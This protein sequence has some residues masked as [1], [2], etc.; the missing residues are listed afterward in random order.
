MK[1]NRIKIGIL[2]SILLLFTWSC[3]D[4]LD[5][6][7]MSRLSTEVEI[8]PSLAAPLAYGSFSIL[9]ILESLNDSSGLISLT[10]DSL[11]LVSFAD[12][13]YSVYAED[14][15]EIPEHISSET[16]IESDINVAGW[17]ALPVGSSYDF[18]KIEK[19]NFEIE[20]DDRIDSMLIKSGTLDLEAYSEFRHAGVLNITSHNIIDPAGDTLDISFTISNTDGTFANDSIFDL[21]GY[22]M[23]MDEIND[24]AVVKIY[25]NLTLIKSPADIGI[26]EEAGMIMTFS[27]IEYKSVF[28]FI[29]E[30]EVTDMNETLEIGFFDAI[31]EIPEIYFADPQFNIAVHNSFGVPLNLDITK[32]TARS[33]IDGSL[34]DLEF[35]ND[36]MNPFTVRAPRVDQL[37]QTITTE[38]YY[39]V[40]TTNIDDILSSIPD[41]IEL[42]FGA[43][44]GNPSG[45]TEQNF[46]LDTS[47]VVVEAEVLLPLWLS[48]SGYTLKDTLDTALD[49]LL[50]NLAFIEDATFRLTTTNEWP[51]EVAIQIYFM[52]DAFTKVDSLFQEQTALI[53][54]APV[55][56]NGELDRALLE[57]NVLDITLLKETLD[58]L[59][60]KGATQLMLVA[61][62][63]TTDRGSKTVK[64]YSQ[65]Q[66][67]YKLAISANFRI[68]PDELNFGSDE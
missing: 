45:S 14:I 32:F 36:T 67:H 53:N 37:G 41:R 15:I 46:V 59:D 43:S 26:N 16:Y 10:E 8:T 2:A 28:G 30:R 61:S 44:T 63:Y 57:T 66:L 4:Y 55:D 13:A 24:S 40:E 47:K 9:D 31:D 52:D 21:S 3:A 33:H 19:M 17:M 7:D 48:T 18:H 5:Q 68:N 60:V 11:I 54:A 42:G 51:L 64:F 12:T 58:N 34:L 22:T 49:S 38:R 25:F 23:T 39:N 1:Q 35:K 6:F 62:A 65:Y 50:M 20:P 56:A 29:A 27:N